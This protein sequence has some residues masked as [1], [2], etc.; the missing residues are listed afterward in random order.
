VKFVMIIALLTVTGAAWFFWPGYPDKLGWMDDVE[1]TA[2]DRARVA[3]LMGRGFQDSATGGGHLSV[4]RSIQQGG[5]RSSVVRRDFELLRQDR[6]RAQAAYPGVATDDLYQGVWLQVDLSARVPADWNQSHNGDSTRGPDGES[7]LD[8]GVYVSGVSP[9]Y[10]D[11]ADVATTKRVLAELKDA[12]TQKRIKRISKWGY[13]SSWGGTGG[14]GRIGCYPDPLPSSEEADDLHVP[15]MCVVVLDDTKYVFPFVPAEWINPSWGGDFITKLA[16]SHQ[17][18]GEPYKPGPVKPWVMEDGLLA[19]GEKCPDGRLCWSKWN[20]DGYDNDNLGPD[21]P[22]SWVI[23]TPFGIAYLPAPDNGERRSV[24]DR[25]WFLVIS[26]Y[27]AAPQVSGGWTEAEAK[28]MLPKFLTGQTWPMDGRDF[29][30]ANRG[31]LKEARATQSP[32]KEGASVLA[33]RAMPVAPSRQSEPARCVQGGTLMPGQ[34]C[35]AW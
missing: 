21:T 19:H 11:R 2:A 25:P 1:F 32:P 26:Y 27:G 9:K 33:D 13:S 35:S 14:S 4:I 20:G 30:E 5:S 8:G 28:A 12:E 6:R 31:N 15:G 16:A 10:P 3:E 7:Y 34:S 18:A 24:S 23:D 29:A 22:A 17:A